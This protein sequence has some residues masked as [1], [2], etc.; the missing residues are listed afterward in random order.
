MLQHTSLDTKTMEMG[1]VHLFLV[2][3]HKFNDEVRVFS[4]VNLILLAGTFYVLINRSE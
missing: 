3:F 2:K 4:S 1:N